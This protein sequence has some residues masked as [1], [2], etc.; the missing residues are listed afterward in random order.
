MA[1]RISPHSASSWRSLMPRRSRGP[2]SLERVGNGPGP[3]TDGILSSAAAD[4]RARPLGQV[5]REQLED[6]YRE[7]RPVPGRPEPPADPDAAR[8]HEVAEPAL[9]P[10]LGAARDRGVCLAVR[11]SP[12]QGADA[13]DRSPAVDGDPDLGLLRRDAEAGHHDA[14]ALG[15]PGRA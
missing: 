9:G 4:L 14:V 3:L 12:S 7:E 2:R 13:P 11:P 10:D 6:V 8:D 5:R 15:P 1:R